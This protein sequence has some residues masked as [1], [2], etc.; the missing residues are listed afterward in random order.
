MHQRIA[1]AV[2]SGGGSAIVVESQGMQNTPPPQQQ[3]SS[4]AVGGHP[5]QQLG[6][7][8]RGDSNSSSSGPPQ[9]IIQ[10][11]IVKHQG[12]TYL[13]QFRAQK[14]IEPGKQIVI[15]TNQTGIGGT[16]LVQEV[17]DEVI[18][19]QYQKQTDQEKINELALQLQQQS[20]QHLEQA[21]AVQK[22]QL[23]AAAET[24]SVGGVATT[25]ASAA[26][27]PPAVNNSN[28][29][30]KLTLQQQQMLLPTEPHPQ[31]AA[32]HQKN[33]QQQQQLLHH[34][35]HQQ[36]QQ[37]HHQEVQQSGR[38][39]TSILQQQLEKGN[40]NKP[41]INNMPVQCMLCIEMPW[42]PNQEHLD[43]HYS[44]AH[45]IMKSTD[46]VETGDLDF[47][48]A[49]LEASLSSMTDLK[50]DAGD[51]ETLLDALPPSPDPNEME[52]QQHKQ[53]V[54][55][56]DALVLRGAVAVATSSTS[57]AAPSSSGGQQQQQ[58][59]GVT[60][61]CELCGFEPRT[62]NK[63]RE[64][65]DHLA[66]KHFR[67]QM[68]SELRKDKPM[69]CPRCDQFESKDRQQLFRHMISKHKVLDFYVAAAVE[70]MKAEGKQPF[71]SS[72]T[73]S[74][75]PTSSSDA[76][77]LVPMLVSPAPSVA[78]AAASSPASRGREVTSS[79]PPQQFLLPSLNI[80][81]IKEEEDNSSGGSPPDGAVSLDPLTQVAAAT[82]YNSNPVTLAEFMES[83]LL[84][85]PPDHHLHSHHNPMTSIKA[86]EGEEE[87]DRIMQVDGVDTESEADTDTE[88]LDGCQMDGANDGGSDSE[89]ESTG[90]GSE[91]SSQ[92][93]PG[94][95]GSDRYN[96][97]ICPV[98]HEEMKHSRIYH[99]AISHFRPRLD[100]ELT[101]S[102]RPF[103]C[104]DCNEEHKHK[105]NLMSHYLGKHQRF[106][107]W[108]RECLESDPKPEWMDPNPPSVRSRGTG[109]GRPAGSGGYM[110]ATT[111]CS[112]NNASPQ[113]SS[114]AVGSES[115]TTTIRGEGGEEQQ[116]EENIKAEDS[117]GNSEMQPAFQPLPVKHEW[118]CELCHGGVTQRKE[119]H[120]ASVHFKDRLRRI[121][122][123][124][125]P[126]IC[127][128]CKMEHK[129]FLN[130]S[131]HYLT[132]HGFLRE[133][134]KAQ[135]IE[136]TTKR[137]GQGGEQAATAAAADAAVVPD[138]E[139]AKPVAKDIDVASGKHA[140]SSGD[141]DY[142][143]SEGQEERG[144]PE[145][146][147]EQQSEKSLLEICLEPTVSESSTT[148]SSQAAD[149]AD[150][151]QGVDSAEVLVKSEEQVPATIEK[152]DE[153]PAARLRRKRLKRT[154]RL[155]IREMVQ[156]VLHEDED[157]GVS[158]SERPASF[159]KMNSLKGSRD[160]P[161]V[162]AMTSSVL[163][164]P[165]P[166]RWLCDGKLL[167]LSDS[168]HEGN[169][170]LFQEQWRRGQPV[171]VANV[172]N[173]LDINLWHPS[174][175]SAEFGHLKHD[176]INCKT[177]K[178]IPQVP[179][180]WFWDGFQSLR[181]RLLDKQGM[182]MLLKLKDWP[183]EDDFA[184]YFPR[185]FA[186]L[187]KWIPLPD[188][189]RREGRFN[190]ASY[191]PD[192]FVCPDL[193]P[194]MYIAYGSSL[195][196]EHGSTN[197][198]LDM[199]DAV[200][201]IVYVGI[202]EDGNREEHYQ[203]GIRAVDEAGCD[204]AT[205]QRVREEGVVVGAL[206][207]IFHPRDAD[208]IRDFLNKVALEKGQKLEP[209]NDPIHDQSIYLDGRLRQRLFEEYGVIGYAY[210]QCEGDTIF[211]PAG[212]PHQ[213]SYRIRIKFCLPS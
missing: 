72:S 54:L 62:K 44:T 28:P 57:I 10:S 155:D 107:P 182:P 194:K 121:L 36:Q 3:S 53:L 20:Q 181:S 88:M 6:Q 43:N 69:K 173:R 162:R 35:L 133:W 151:K 184:Q 199:S 41:K 120:Y 37:H 158:S 45:G 169:L 2:T 87:E 16:A 154:T 187:M 192:F 67:D 104:P 213:V 124:A 180:K 31:I 81:G 25:A 123:N 144:D 8:Q 197:L 68:I 71:Y 178:L 17:M 106:E 118:F 92:E 119:A 163:T 134:L 52:P 198:H 42:F 116:E 122:P 24:A 21:S 27:P 127:I 190:L 34:Q 206:W 95:K 89:V 186:D 113:R 65:M 141:S 86:E 148:G 171:V 75:Q 177:H 157:E 205:R 117:E 202:P 170:G 209:H 94:V 19:Q 99:F 39:T 61:L 137:R 115:E 195:Y 85:T 73:S 66:M 156:S 26:G 100:R 77:G 160:P 150:N 101:A 136:L 64:R 79:L 58:Q 128:I 149:R 167:L 14:P 4:A 97:G 175:F 76:A 55:S 82:S 138:M 203:A 63:S 48:N 126:F 56:P 50:D 33:Q 207:H 47:S 80:M 38:A 5:Q 103:P 147:L 211:I 139:A 204:L 153:K 11:K 131:T 91:F 102:R 174:A 108:L 193:G 125:A 161:P 130:L 90:M 196:P 59:Q 111:S 132:Q 159:G 93:D 46:P 212:A 7:Q 166:H 83:D 152:E 32:Q 18:R 140:L 114:A 172:S 146:L 129:H 142:E 210:P 200:N 179:L 105:M 51:F 49:D 112:S 78:A 22:Q 165:P 201:L 109:G 13:V 60:R 143:D 183:P 70:R 168:I 74:N 15:R 189:T 1:Q 185:R 84:G 29:V 135:G 23:T 164:D 208:R 98:C 191:M 145:L 188:Y 9:H 30:T 12:R 96:K 176:I 40:N 110:S